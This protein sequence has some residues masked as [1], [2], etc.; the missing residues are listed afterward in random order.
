MASSYSKLSLDRAHF[1][2]VYKPLKAIMN[3]QYK[4]VEKPPTS[5]IVNTYIQFLLFKNH[6]KL[7]YF[8]SKNTIFIR[9]SSI[10]STKK[11]LQKAKLEVVFIVC[12]NSP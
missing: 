6:L 8:F 3:F 1:I 2:S 5:A 10:G 11:R 4:F 9:R 12:L 7:I